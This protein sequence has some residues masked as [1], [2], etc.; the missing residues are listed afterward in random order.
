MSKILFLNIA[1]ILSLIFTVTA[2]QSQQNL[3]SNPNSVEVSEELRQKI[4]TDI[5]EQKNNFQLCQGDIDQSISRDSSS[6]YR[7]KENQYLV[8]ILC[9]LGAYQ[10]NYQYFFYQLNDANSP[11]NPLSF[12]EFRQ[13]K[14]NDFRVKSSVNIGGIPDYHQENKILTIYTKGRGLADCGSFAKYQWQD[15]QFELLEYRVKEQCD[16][17]YLEPENYPQI[18]P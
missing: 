15:A 4:L 6:V 2:C 7:L 10:G 17:N 5:Y 14:S 3:N 12:Q 11:I 8:E 16:G 1:L 9:F 18:Y 13:N